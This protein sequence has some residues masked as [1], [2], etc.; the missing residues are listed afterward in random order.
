M[1]KTNIEL[2]AAAKNVAANHKTLYVLGCFGAPMNDANKKR[3]TSNLAFN[4]KNDRKPKILA[5]SAV[6][7]GFDCSG[8]VKGLLWGWDGDPAQE[9]GGA[10]YQNNGVPD[11]NADSMIA[12]CKDVSTDFFN[13]QVGE[14]VWIKG[15]VGLYIGNGLAVEC[16]H[17][18]KDGVQITRVHNIL[19]DD[20]APGRSWEK[21]GKLPW[22]TYVEETATEPQDKP[23]EDATPGIAL[24]TLRNGDKGEDVRAMQILLAGNG[25][26]GQMK[27]SAYGSFG[28]KTADAVK[29]YQKA[30]GLTQDGICGPETWA[31]L[32]GVS[33]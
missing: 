27:A 33:A 20:G 25:C 1:F 18:W 26:N 11:I 30:K 3:Y 12:K 9:Y 2:A 5:A 6:T 17:R 24:R 4:K 8:F 10:T 15:H 7:F 13:I 32:L 29:L 16:T 14:V 19:A 28:S 21:H 23:Q 31:A 22:I